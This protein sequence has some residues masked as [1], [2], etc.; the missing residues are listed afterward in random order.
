M[1]TVDGYVLG[2]TEAELKRLATQARLIDPI[3]RRFLVS[4]GITEGMRVLDVG[5]G[6]G[7]VA[8]LLA[9]LVGPKG[10]IV[11]T[12]PA[13]IAIDAAEKRIKTSSLANVTFRHGDP[14]AMTFDKPFDGCRRSIRP[15][16]HPRAVGRHCSPLAPP[17]WRRPHVFPRAQ[18]GWRAILAARCNL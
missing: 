9:D 3:T 18:L 10:E 6:A 4:A 8:I 14:A 5:S 1:V 11:G 2:H 7:D 17:S 13:S 16:V 12:D 15:A